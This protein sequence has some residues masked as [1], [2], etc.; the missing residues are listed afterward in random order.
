MATKIYSY[1]VHLD[2]LPEVAWDQLRLAHRYYN[3]LIELENQRRGEYRALRTAMFPELAALEVRQEEINAEI[4]TLEAQKKAENANSRK[5]VKNLD[6]VARLKTLKEER[7][8]VNARVKNQRNL[9]RPLTC[10]TGEVNGKGEPKMRPL[11]RDELED[12]APSTQ[13]DFSIRCIQLDAEDLER[14]KQARA[15]CGVYWTTYLRI[16]RAVQQAG[17]TSTTDPR[18]KRFTGEGCLGGQIQGGLSIGDALSGSSLN[19]K[20]GRLPSSSWATRRAWEHARTTVYLRIQSENRQPV[21]LE[22]PILMDRPLPSTGLIKEAY[23]KCVKVGLK[24]HYAL[25][26]AIDSEE[27]DC[28]NPDK[29]D[30]LAQRNPMPATGGTVAINFGWRTLPNGDVRVAYAVDAGGHQESLALPARVKSAYDLVERLQGYADEHFDAAR[31]QLVSFLERGQDVPAW[32]QELCQTLSQWR[33]HG[34]LAV[35]AARLRDEVIGRERAQVLWEGYRSS[36][37]THGPLP[38]YER[39]TSYLP[40]AT[41]LIKLAWYLEVWRKK[42]KHLVEYLSNLRQ[43][44]QDQRK[45]LFRCWSKSMASRYATLVID[46]TNFA[47]MS[48]KAGVGEDGP[49][50]EEI[51][52]SKEASPGELRSTLK[53]KFGRARVIELPAPRKT[54]T[55]CLC[56]QD[57]GWDTK[58]RYIQ[59]CPVLERELDQDWNN[60]QNLL[61]EHLGDPSESGPARNEESPEFSSSSHEVQVVAVAVGQ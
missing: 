41:D 57:H 52:A 4:D 24:M 56:G 36:T 14:C 40:E 27:F 12:L 9:A 61:R 44:C 3:R 13:R 31:G 5:K 22:L 53:E 1:H 60:C 15:E 19:L 43:K 25:K 50:S 28:L 18:F 38:S 6:L 39:V 17:K 33:S 29:R 47:Q 21:W 7:K 32:L 11:T 49:S 45:D 23:V 34:R 48:R 2:T 46:N 59:R 51:H 26:L 37:S 30:I 54:I 55:C 10:P 58:A 42:D 8:C 16:E 20:I 35:V